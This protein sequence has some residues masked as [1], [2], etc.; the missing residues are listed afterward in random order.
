MLLK[1]A[2]SF[3]DA[4]TDEVRASEWWTESVRGE[5]TRRQRRPPTPGR[6]PPMKPPAIAPNAFP[7]SRRTYASRC[8]RG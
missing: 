4:A 3:K 2:L 7:K 6:P 8:V 1:D 5:L